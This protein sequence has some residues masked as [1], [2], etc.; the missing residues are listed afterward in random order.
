MKA[1]QDRCVTKEGVVTHLRKHNTNL[2]NEQD[3]YKDALLTLN[4]ELKLREKLEEE[5]HQKEKL[6]EAKTSVE[7]ELTTLLGQVETT[8]ANVVQEFKAAQLF[9]DSC[10]VYYG[11]G[12]ED[13]LK[14][15]AS[16]YPN[17]D[18]SKITMDDPLPSTPVGDTTIGESDN[19]TELELPPKGDGVV[20]AQ[21]AVDPPVPPSNS[22][23]ELLDEENPLAQDKDNKT[24]QDAPIA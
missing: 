24:L 18:L 10:G 8:R 9:I 21:P 22:S 12:F 19:S 7:K 20:L 15:V 11:T 4:V 6:Q 17:L 2:K 16:V 5:S 13:C 1:L 23:I 3:Q 14:Q